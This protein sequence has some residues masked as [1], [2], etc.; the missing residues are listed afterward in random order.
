MGF[1]NHTRKKHKHF[2]Y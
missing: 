1:E 2:K